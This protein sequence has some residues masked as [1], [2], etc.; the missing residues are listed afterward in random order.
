MRQVLLLGSGGLSIGQ[1]GEF[2]YSGTQAVRSL[3]EEGC[4]VIVVNPNVATV[5]TDP[6]Q[7][8]KVYL[9]PVEPHWVERVIEKEHPWGLVAGFGGQTALNCA[10]ELDRLGVLRRHKVRNLGTPIKTLRMTEDRG[11]FAAFMRRIGVP[12]PPSCAVSS[13]DAARRWCDRLGYPVIVRAA[14]ALGGLGSGFAHN[15]RQLKTLVTEALSTS[16]Q[17]LVEKSLVGWREV[18]YEVMRDISGD[19]VAICNMENLDP[20]GIHTGDSVVV[21]PSQT[22]DDTEFQRLRDESLKIVRAAGIIGECNVQ[23]ALDPTS[24]RHYVIEVNARLS[25][26]SALASKASGYPIAAVAAKVVL[27]RRLVNL[28]NPVTG[29]T[30]ALY[31]PAFDYVTVKIPRWDL[32]KFQGVSSHLGPM[33]KSVGEVMAVG[34]TFPEALQKGVRMVSEDTRGLSR[35]Y[36]QTTRR[37]LLKDLREPT[38]LR[39]YALME[40]FRRGIKLSEVRRLTRIDPW[41]LRH[42]ESLAAQERLI[43]GKRS[44]THATSEEWRTWKTAGFGDEQIAALRLGPSAA[45]QAA[46]R[47]ALR[48]RRLREREGVRPFVKRID[49]TAG[50]YPSITNYLY[51]SYAASAHDV[52][53]S[54]GRKTALILGAGA[55]RVGSSVEFD[56]C[57]VRASERFRRSGW[58]S[59]TLNCNPETVST[60]FNSSDRLYFE[61]LTLERILDIAR[62]E[63]VA[64]VVVSMGGQLPNRLALPLAHAGLRLLGH[65]PTAI[66]TAEDRQKFSALLDLVDVDQPAWVNAASR[67]GVDRFVRHVG[68][69]VLIRPSYVLSGAAMSIAHDRRSLE[70]SLAA[71]ANFSDKH[72]VVVSKFLQG[73]REIEL[74]GVACRGRIVVS[75][76]AEHV[77]NA[78]VH[79]GDATIVIPA[80][81]LYVET[82]RQVR[83]A[84]RRIVAALRLHGPFN[85]QFLALANRIYVIECNARASRS[86]PFASKV[87]GT[88]LAD[89]AARIMLGERPKG[90]VGAREDDLGHVGVKAALF[91]FKRLSGSDPV[92]GVEMASTGEVGCLGRDYDEALLLAL[93]SAGV[94]PPR[95]GI[96]VSAGPEAEKL[97]FLSAV[98]WATYHRVPLYATDGTARFLQAHGVKARTLAWPGQGAGDVLKAIRG[99]QVDF[100]VNVPKN[101]DPQELTY[102]REIRRTAIRFGCS[103]LTDIDIVR[104][105]FQ[106]LERADTTTNRITLLSVPAYMED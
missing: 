71:A 92:L 47:L 68:F 52:T 62:F 90:R 14:Y 28:P 45:P 22:L 65:P 42:F 23:F 34:R 83:M 2:D 99:G 95:R 20:L 13:S 75:V 41:F 46:E 69:P 53:P 58:T 15:P 86:F 59:I 50:E 105:Y 1:G 102:G 36:S 98:R 24:N 33:M 43:A 100:V 94:K 39:L 97:R 106:A 91:S 74:D 104:D 37:S 70:R 89:L 3:R 85:I 44:L 101:L 48:V 67:A 82:V 80:Q 87:L 51:M 32:R 79:S 56:W 66:D 31:E 29:V 77:E 73:A 26:S 61:E 25:R 5:Q 57:A 10:M 38:D 49:T 103:L 88:N 64:G 55:Y 76:L 9:Y 4:E 84:A 8:V 12:V 78:G 30:K 27:G 6:Q 21:A 72:P 54:R 40:A 16:P 96:L 81:R 93:E 18:E 35:P 17:V 11:L 7:G 63:R 19:A 60:D